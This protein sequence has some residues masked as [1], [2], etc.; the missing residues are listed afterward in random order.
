MKI[1]IKTII[2]WIEIFI[3]A[4]TLLSASIVQFS[5]AFNMQPKPLNVYIFVTLTAIMAVVFGIGL[6]YDGKWAVR[7]LI[8]FSGYIILTK[9]LVYAGL[10]SFAGAIITIVPVALKDGISIL[11]HSALIIFLAIYERTSQ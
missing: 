7:L 11:Y 9:V 10:L 6:L 3:G 4:I 8:F 1:L 2:A 5:G